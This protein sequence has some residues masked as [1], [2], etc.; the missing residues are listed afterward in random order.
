MS[1][2]QSIS[3]ENV[4]LPASNPSMST[5][6]SDQT[7]SVERKVDQ[8]KSMIAEICIALGLLLGIIISTCA[9]L[10]D[11]LKE[12][13]EVFFKSLQIILSVILIIYSPILVYAIIYKARENKQKRIDD[14]KKAKDD[15]TNRE[16]E[17]LLRQET[18]SLRESEKNG[19]RAVFAIAESFEKN[20]E[21]K[22]KLDDSQI[23]K[24]E[25]YKT[26]MDQLLESQ[27]SDKKARKDKEIEICSRLDSI[28]DAIKDRNRNKIEIKIKIEQIEQKGP[29]QNPMPKM[30]KSLKVYKSPF[31]NI[32]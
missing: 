5:H 14:A 11:T 26:K 30:S 6:E 8:R 21:I 17:V 7:P 25:S 22:L 2:N 10:K 18:R 29:D 1:T 28:E 24:V 12:L 3:S 27:K 15:K 13:N 32:F 4:S 16:D 23:A 9:L 20:K 19:R 31:S